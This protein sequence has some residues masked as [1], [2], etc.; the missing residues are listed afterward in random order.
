MN[1]QLLKNCEDK[2][3]SALEHLAV[4]FSGVRSGRANGGLVD[5]IKVN[6]YGQDTPLKSIATISTPDAKTIQIQPWDAGNLAAIEKA[7][8]M[9]EHMGLNPSNDGRLIRINIPPLSEETRQQMVKL[10]NQK[11]EEATISLRNARHEALNEAK[12]SKELSEDESS[13]LDKEVTKLIEQFQKQVQDSA[14][15]K[16]AELMQN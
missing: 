11:A 1:N 4:E 2:M 16:E 3:K 7:I 13:R 5:S 14:K 6:V 10:I 15:S 9:Q 8:S 12:K